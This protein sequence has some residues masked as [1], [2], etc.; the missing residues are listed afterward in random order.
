MLSLKEYLA[1][2]SLPVNDPSMEPDLDDIDEK[3]DALMR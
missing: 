1:V 3:A 2:L